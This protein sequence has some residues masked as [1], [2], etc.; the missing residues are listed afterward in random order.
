MGALGGGGVLRWGN[1][2]RLEWNWET[3]GWNWRHW[4]RA[5][6]ELNGAGRGLGAIRTELGA[7][8]QGWTLA[9]PA[10]TTRGLC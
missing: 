6:G 10:L 5:G 2:S 9:E 1:E 3:L 8:G 4:D 7:R